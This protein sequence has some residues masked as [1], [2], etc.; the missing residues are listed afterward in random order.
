MTVFD[1]KLFN[2][3]QPL[4]IQ[5][6]QNLMSPQ[7][8]YQAFQNSKARSPRP[9]YFALLDSKIDFLPPDFSL[10]DTLK[11]LDY[12]A[13]KFR[14]IPPACPQAWS[15]VKI[16]IRCKNKTIKGLK[17]T[18]KTTTTP[19][20][21]NL[22]LTL[23]NH[24]EG[25]I[26][27]VIK[28]RLN[29]GQPLAF[30]TFFNPDFVWQHGVFAEIPLGIWL[31]SHG[32]TKDLPIFKLAGET[33]AIWEWIND[34]MTPHQR[35][36]ITYNHIA[37][38]YNLIALNPLNRSNYNAHNIRLD[39]GGIQPNFRGRRWLAIVDGTRFYT[40]KLRQEGLSFLKNYLHRD[41]VR[42]LS[43]RLWRELSLLFQERSKKPSPPT[44]G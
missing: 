23:E 17:I 21:K 30:K 4:I 28:V 15:V 31:T 42:Y 13:Q 20:R 1:Y 41:R 32:A 19:C 12:L 33:W 6:Q 14:T 40:R 24:S 25:M 37:Q 36:G 10:T 43:Q 5:A 44:G 29:G 39:L 34:D 3:T 38:K 11:V 2:E 9:L 35:E 27:R 26:G 18:I 22:N 8:F 16:K 7:S